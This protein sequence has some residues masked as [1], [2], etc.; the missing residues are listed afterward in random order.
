MGLGSLAVFDNTVISMFKSTT[1]KLFNKEKHY[2][3][4]CIEDRQISKYYPL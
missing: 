4:L 2:L 1:R 3:I